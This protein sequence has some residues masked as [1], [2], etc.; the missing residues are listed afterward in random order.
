MPLTPVRGE[1]SA[2]TATSIPITLSCSLS[3]TRQTAVCQSGTSNPTG[4]DSVVPSFWHFHSSKFIQPTD[5]PRCSAHCPIIPLPQAAQPQ[6]CVCVCLPWQTPA[7]ITIGV[8]A[9][10]EASGAQPH[11]RTNINFHLQFTVYENNL[12][13]FYKCSH[14]VSCLY[15]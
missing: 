4:S 2:G 6:G 3:S 5:D 10:L 1:L 15:N 12:D 11:P 7:S 8:C 9:T 13:I 14:Y